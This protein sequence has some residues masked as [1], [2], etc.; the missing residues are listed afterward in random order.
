MALLC[1]WSGQVL[2]VA[3]LGATAVLL[4]GYRRSPLARLR[5]QEIKTGGLLDIQPGP[6]GPINL[7]PWYSYRLNVCMLLLVSHRISGR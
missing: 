6:F 5:K 4:F 3:P 2:T 1:V 7:Q